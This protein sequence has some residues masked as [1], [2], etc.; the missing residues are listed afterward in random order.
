[1]SYYQPERI[2]SSPTINAVPSAS[3]ATDEKISSS[4]FWRA[5]LVIY[6][7]SILTPILFSFGSVNFTSSRLV[8]FLLLLPVIWGI[9]TSLVWHVV[10]FLIIAYAIWAIICFVANQGVN[11]SIESSGSHFVEVVV[12]Y[13]LA[14][15]T[16]KKP[17]DYAFWSKCLWIAILVLLPLACFESLTGRPIVLEYLRGF[18]RVYPNDGMPLRIGLDRAQVTFEHPIL[19][20]VFCAGA[21]SPVLLVIGRN[22]SWIKKSFMATVVAAA[23]FF[24]LSTGAYLNV[25][26]QILIMVWNKFL[27]RMKYRWR[28]FGVLFLVAYVAVDIVS[29]R[30]PFEVFISYL[31]FDPF[32]AFTRI[33]QWRAGTEEVFRNPIFGMG[34]FSDYI[35][36]E[37]LPLS[38]DNFWLLRAMRFGFPGVILLILAT[39]IAARGAASRINVDDK[40][41]SAVSSAQ[42]FALFGSSV[43]LV[44]V[45]IWSG[46]HTLFFFALGSVISL[47]QYVKESEAIQDEA[48]QPIET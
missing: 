24:S 32:S 10:D 31:T 7:I 4:A 25:L 39:F 43:S 44:T 48:K 23:T 41:L 13:F 29:N 42:L 27:R 37:W 34:L 45:D 26:W 3:T 28:L 30:T 47:T 16:F 12:G 38:I 2:V 40:D 1:M 36:P 17:I 20:G 14:R 15:V 33:L 8:L 19:Y 46:S 22:K 11:A 5:M 21:F 6:L 18:L 35:R 9:A